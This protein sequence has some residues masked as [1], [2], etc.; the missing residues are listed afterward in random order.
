[1]RADFELAETYRHQTEAPLGVLLHVF[2]GADDTRVDRPEIEAWRQHSNSS[3]Q[4]RE[5]P[6]DHSYLMTARRPVVDAVTQIMAT[7]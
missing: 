1:M 5:F 2:A 6:G 7:D 3:T 4:I